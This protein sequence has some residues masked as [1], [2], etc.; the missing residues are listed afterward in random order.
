MI[1]EVLIH[2]RIVLSESGFEVYRGSRD[3]RGQ[4]ENEH[5]GPLFLRKRPYYSD[6]IK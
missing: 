2:E 4:R 5:L 3:R 6:G 1:G